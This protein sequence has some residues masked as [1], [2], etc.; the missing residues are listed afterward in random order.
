[1]KILVAIVEID[2]QNRDIFAYISYTKTILSFYS[3]FTI[4]SLTGALVQEA[5]GCIDNEKDKKDTAYGRAPRYA[6]FVY[7][8]NSTMR[9]SRTTTLKFVEIRVINRRVIEPRRIA[10]RARFEMPRMDANE[11]VEKVA[12]LPDKD[13]RAKIHARS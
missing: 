4:G 1:M 11:V 8:T 6:V 2:D 5:R 13:T 12:L 3:R 9:S 7:K 10:L